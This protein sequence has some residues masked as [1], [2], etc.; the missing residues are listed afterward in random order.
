[1]KRKILIIAIVA[2]LIFSCIAFVACRENSVD[3]KLTYGKKYIRENSI[4]ADSAYES[5][6]I[7]SKNGTGIYFYHETFEGYDYI[8]DRFTDMIISYTITFKYFTDSENEVV[9]CFYDSFKYEPDHN[10]RDTYD[11]STWNAVFNFNENFLMRIDTGATFYFTEEFL[12]DT[13]PNYGK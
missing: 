9:Y 5:Y 3:N 7:F 12:N 10:Y 2:I 1:M 6:F 8:T 4:S 11:D 13:L